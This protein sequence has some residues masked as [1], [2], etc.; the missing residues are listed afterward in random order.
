MIWAAI[1]VYT[2]SEIWIMTSR[3]DSARYCEILENGLVA[4][5]AR[6]VWGGKVL[7]LSTR[8]CSLSYTPCVEVTSAMTQSWLRSHSITTLPW[9]AKSPDMNTKEK[10]WAILAR[11]FY[12]R[13]RK[14]ST[15]DDL[16]EAIRDFWASGRSPAV[17]YSFL[18][19]CVVNCYINY[20][21]IFDADF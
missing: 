19:Q 16:E 8:Q 2:V 4:F 17:M 15:V 10:L 14:F 6:I 7:G 11:M 9:P 13:G 21:G 5:C 12:S 18:T 3:Q 20:T 1:S